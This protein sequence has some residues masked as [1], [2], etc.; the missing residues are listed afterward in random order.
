MI[1]K[2]GLGIDVVDVNNFKKIKFASKPN[3]YKKIFHPSEIK[4]CLKYKNPYEHFAGKF[5]VKEAVKKAINE[6]IS[7]LDIITLQS[8]S[9]PVVQIKNKKLDNYRFLVSITH[10]KNFAVGVVISEKVN[11]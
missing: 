5:A 3:F 6:K 9:K 8:K 10:E 1:K 4:Y 11:D 2:F 7:M